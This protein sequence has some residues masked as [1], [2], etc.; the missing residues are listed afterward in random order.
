MIE[1]TQINCPTCGVQPHTRS[2]P[3]HVLHLLL[4][5]FTFGFWLIIWLFIGLTSAD[6]FRCASCGNTEGQARRAHKRA[7]KAEQKRKTPPKLKIDK[8]PKEGD[9][10]KVVSGEHKGKFGRLMAIDAHSA[11]IADKKGR[12]VV[13][14]PVAVKTA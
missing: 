7:W 12:A 13:V 4:T 11:T 10:V 8:T 9:R 6:G 5:V 2:R 1:T 3:N 14:H